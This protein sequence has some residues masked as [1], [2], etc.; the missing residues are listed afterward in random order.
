MRKS[1]NSA[2]TEAAVANAENPTGDVNEALFM[3]AA[4]AFSVGRGTANRN[5]KGLYSMAAEGFSQVSTAWRERCLPFLPFLDHLA[6]DQAEKND[7]EA[8]ESNVRISPSLTLKNGMPISLRGLKSLA[9]FTSMPGRMIDYLYRGDEE[10]RSILAR[11]MNKALNQREIAWAAKNGSPR[12]F[13]LRFRT[14]ADGRQVLRAVLSDDY[15]CFDNVTAVEMLRDSIT[16]RG[17]NDA[18]LSYAWSDGDRVSLGLLLPDHLKMDAGSEWGVIIYLVNSEVGDGVYEVYGGLFQTDTGTGWRWV[19]RRSTA[20]VRIIHRGKIDN[21]QVLQDVRKAVEVAL[22]HGQSL[23]A[24][25]GFAREVKVVDPVTAI[26]G[27]GKSVGL[28]QDQ[29]KGVL[30]AYVQGKMT[31][32][33]DTWFSVA[34]SVTKFALTCEGQE[35]VD[36]ETKASSILAENLK[37]DGA[38]I[39][40][41]AARMADIGEGLED[42]Y[43]EQLRLLYANA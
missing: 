20:R 42:K 21:R 27:A 17:T 19:E 9:E 41:R 1:I 16:E 3:P 29:V 36:L 11:Q 32:A 23:A 14:I 22:T 25:L 33:P 7:V 24:L 15:A 31:G 43:L 18:L 6:K 30:E 34:D 4:V 39:A 5:A 28:S 10:D 2:I 12:N 13:L 8:P 37:S 26:A 40:R 35:R 38:D